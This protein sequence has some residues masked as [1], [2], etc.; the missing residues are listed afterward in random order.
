[1]LLETTNKYRT[2]SEIDA[3]DT[4]EAYRAQAAEKGYLIKKAS[5]EYKNKKSKG[6]IVA[7]AWVVTITQVFGTLWE[8]LA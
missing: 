6:E 4:I 3:K 7:E 1:M 8:D 5:Y 2:D